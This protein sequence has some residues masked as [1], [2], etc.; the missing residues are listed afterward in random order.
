MHVRCHVG[1][2]GGL[3]RKSL[4]YSSLSDCCAF[5]SAA[6]A[7]GHLRHLGSLTKYRESLRPS[8]SCGIG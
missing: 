5:A 8:R 2:R 6:L 1:G 3:G 7:P 4:R